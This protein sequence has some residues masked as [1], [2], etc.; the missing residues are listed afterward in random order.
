MK[1]PADRCQGRACS[2]LVLRIMS[3][4]TSS[5]EKRETTAIFQKTMCNI[6]QFSW[7][8][9]CNIPT[10]C[11]PQ[12]AAAMPDYAANFPRRQH[13]FYAAAAPLTGFMT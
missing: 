5:T 8:W 3:R 1:Q 13:P 9:Y 2:K 12:A 4:A 11:P 6:A 10:R 7:H